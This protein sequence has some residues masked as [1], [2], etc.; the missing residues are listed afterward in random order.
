MKNSARSDPA[1][2]WCESNAYE[3]QDI[4]SIC[5]GREHWLVDVWQS[6]AQQTERRAGREN[7]HLCVC[8]KAQRDVINDESTDAITSECCKDRFLLK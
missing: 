6:T 8:Q 3:W 1:P 5:F 4:W 7:T 2:V